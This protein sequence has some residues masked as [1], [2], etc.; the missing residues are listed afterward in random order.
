MSILKAEDHDA[1]EMHNV[2]DLNY[3]LSPC[4]TKRNDT[5]LALVL[6]PLQ[7]PE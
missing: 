5:V 6:T 3:V 1:T 4:C 7:F 2:K